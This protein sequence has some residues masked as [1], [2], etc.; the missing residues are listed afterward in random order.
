MS[1]FL[2]LAVASA[3][4]FG[5]SFVGFQVY[6]RKNEQVAIKSEPYVSQALGI[7][8]G[9]NV[10][11]DR[12]GSPLT[13]HNISRDPSENSVDPLAGNAKL[14]IPVSGSKGPSAFLY[15]WATRPPITT[16]TPKNEIPEWKINQL[17]IELG[18]E[19]RW[20]FYIHK[21][22]MKDDKLKVSNVDIPEK[23]WEET[24]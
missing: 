5:V 4:C 12:L 16:E 14:K 23:L 6:K 10:V 8:Q 2:E 20:T 9:Y 17:D 11:M 24:S 18:P 13:L 22:H 3:G 21:D 7:L 19:Y 15:L 1:R